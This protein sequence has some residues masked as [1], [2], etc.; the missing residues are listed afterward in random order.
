MADPE[1]T[2]RSRI[3]PVSPA[4]FPGRGRAALQL[5]TPL[6]SFIGR[7]REIASVVDLLRRDDI[8]LLTLTGPGGAGKTRLAIRVAEAVA[9]DF[10]DGVWF[11]S[12][13]PVR[14][15][16]LIAATIARTLEVQE[17]GNRPIAEGIAAF[18]AGRRGLVI[19]D[20]FEHVLDAGPLVTDL[21]VACPALKV[22]VTSRSVLRLSGEHDIVVPRLSLPGRG[23]EEA[24]SRQADAPLLDSS[25][26]VRL[27]VVRATA[28]DAEFALTDANAA[29]VAAICGRLDGLPLAIELAAARVRSLSPQAM[30]RRLDQRLRLLTGGARDQPVRLRSMRDAIAW[31]YDLLTLEEQ[32]LFRRLA[33]FVGG[34]TLEAAEAV[35]QAIDLRHG[36]VLDGIAALVDKSL[37]QAIEESSEEPRY[38]MLETIREF[39]VEQ[40]AVSGDEIPTR[41]AHVALVVSLAEQAAAELLGR[42]QG[43]WLKQLEVE[44]PNVRT[45]LGWLEHTGDATTRLRV[46]GAIWWFWY[47]RGHL[48]EGRMWLERALADGEDASSSL[49]ARALLAVSVLASGQTDFHVALAFADASLAVADRIGDLRG[50]AAAHF[51]RGMVPQMLGDYALAVARLGAALAD[52]RQ[53]DDP[54][55]VAFTLSQMGDAVFGLPDLDRAVALHEE[56][57]VVLRELGGPWNTAVTLACLGNVVLE[58]GDL[59]RAEDLFRES[60]TLSWDIDDRWCVGDTL[61]SL[62]IVAERRGQLQRAARLIGAVD[63]V[64]DRVQATLML[65]PAQ[66]ARYEHTIDVVRAQLGDQAFAAARAAGRAMP[67]AEAIGEAMIATPPLP[68]DPGRTRSSAGRAPGELTPRE[69]DVLKLVVAGR[70]NREIAEALFISVPTVKSHL[71]SILGKLDVPSRSAAT[72]YAHAHGLL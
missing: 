54:V 43:R 29:D 28:A 58:Q 60:L 48:R 5:P 6:T 31:S 23:V 52:W 15:P 16:G 12:L 47:I 61:A 57:L 22:L 65:I 35:V 3:Q 70:S 34:F 1:R 25:E 42:D 10:P 66:A 39:G 13:A 69:Q 68:D 4:P 46:A 53:V 72:A 8:R 67:L 45:A 55:W 41:D 56:A 27:F 59:T 17:A 32:A 64:G 71:T 50:V 19:L 11:V 40:L 36:D 30:L 33:V 62:A 63:A 9:A 37:L 20:N 14:D 18:L 21:L 51:M 38:Q 44:L 7:E 24:G 2:E 26:A 49:R